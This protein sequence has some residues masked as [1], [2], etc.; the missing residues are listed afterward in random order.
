[1]ADL[2]NALSLENISIDYGTVMPVLNAS[3]ELEAGGSLGIVGE[4]GCGKSSLLKAVAGIENHWTGSM[5]AFGKPLPK[6]RTLADARV[7]QMVFQDPLASLNPSHTVDDI[8]REPLSIHNI[9]D[10]DRRILYAMD[11][12]ALSRSLR[13]RFPGQLSGGQRQRVGI[14]RALQIEPEILLLDEPTSALDVSVQAEV[15]NLLSELR[16]D[17]GLSYLVVSHDLAVVA[18]LCER[19]V[20]MHDGYFVESLQR[21]HIQS[22]EAKHSCSRNLLRHVYQ[23]DI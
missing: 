6:R 11:S 3:L 1:M 19:V 21:V 9:G 17:R 8:L 7:I 5:L 16:K 15:L 18:Q 10:R 13:Y 22:G 20:V 14:A 23:I 12:V 2:I 4:S